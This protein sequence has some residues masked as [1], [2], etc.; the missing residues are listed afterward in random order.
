MKSNSSASRVIFL[1]VPESL[2]GQIETLSKGQEADGQGFVIDPAI[3]IP[4]ELS[5]GMT[6]LDLGELSWEM[7][8]SGMIRVIADDPD[9]EDAPYYRRF[10]LS[11]KPDMLAEFTEAAIIKAR[12][13]DYA[14]AL[15]II[16]ALEGLFPRSPVVLLNKAL[17]L[18]KQAENQENAGLEPE[19]DLVY[20]AYQDVLSVQ[21]RFPNGFFNAGFFFMKQGNFETAKECFQTYVMLMED[22]EKHEEPEKLEKAKAILKEIKSRSLDDAIFRE[23]YTCIRQGEEQKG[24]SKIRNFLERHPD[25]WNGWFILGWGLRKLGRWEDGATAFKKTIELGGDSS[26]TRNELAIC[27]MECG[28]LVGA[29]KELELCL[30]EEPE[31]VKIISNLG[32]VALRNGDDN[33]AAGFFRTVLELEPTDPLALEY[34]KHSGYMAPFTEDFE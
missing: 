31:N 18:E 22:A 30:R 28:D 26:D 3:P 23:A 29:R 16:A 11:V 34:F 14:L 5:P 17:I 27:L 13:G 6:N 12:N 24:L 19:T 4:V 20:Q 25:V 15:E 32:I 9:D 33:E 1:S 8:L 21:P 7:I 10:V 2:R